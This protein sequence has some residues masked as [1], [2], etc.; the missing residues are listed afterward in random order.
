VVWLGNEL[1][2]LII[3]YFNNYNFTKTQ[4]IHS[5]MMMIERKHVGAVLM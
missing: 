3:Y 1:I 2:I 4:I 5:L